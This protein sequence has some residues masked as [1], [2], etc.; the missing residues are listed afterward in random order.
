M[1]ITMLQILRAGS[2][3]FA[4]SSHTS[5]P[6]AARGHCNP[7]GAGCVQP[8]SR[9]VSQHLWEGLQ[10]RLDQLLRVGLRDA[11]LLGQPR[12]SLPIHNAVHHALGTLPLLPADLVRPAC[13][14]TRQGFELANA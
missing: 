3:R 8:T 1:Y 2:G 5:H 9:I 10:E 12:R 7:H 14:Q 6:S 13:R 11:Q 4:S